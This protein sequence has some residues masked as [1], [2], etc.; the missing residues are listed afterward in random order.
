MTLELIEEVKVTLSYCIASITEQV[1][2]SERPLSIRH[3]SG[4]LW[5]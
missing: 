1:S 2:H 5:V 4:L 3:E